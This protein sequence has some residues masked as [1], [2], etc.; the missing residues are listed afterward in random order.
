MNKIPFELIKEIIPD[1][2]Q[3]FIQRILNMS[4]WLEINFVYR[5]KLYWICYQQKYKDKRFVLY[6]ANSDMGMQGYDSLEQL[7]EHGEIDGKKI[8]NIWDEI[9]IITINSCNPRD[10]YD[11]IE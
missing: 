4:P 11:F 7:Y 10:Y 2:K 8:K 3:N 6:E 9:T 1:T 5:Q